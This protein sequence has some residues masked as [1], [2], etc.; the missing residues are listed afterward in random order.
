MDKNSQIFERRKYNNRKEDS[1]S[2]LKW[3]VVAAFYNNGGYMSY[4]AVPIPYYT[5][6]KYEVTLYKRKF[7]PSNLL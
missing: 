2:Q 7:F 4:K 3:K 1:R 6:R 5:L